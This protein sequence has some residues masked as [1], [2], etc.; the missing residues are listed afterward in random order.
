MTARLFAV[1]RASRS[2]PSLRALVP[3]NL[4]TGLEQVLCAIRTGGIA[5]V[6]EAFFRLG[7]QDREI[8]G[9]EDE[10][11]KTRFDVAAGCTELA[12]DGQRVNELTFEYATVFGVELHGGFQT[13]LVVQAREFLWRDPESHSVVFNTNVHDGWFSFN[14]VTVTCAL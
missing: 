9:V 12:L 5:C 10:Q 14:G 2:R 8:A 7:I 4:H 1:E 6:H 13:A 11:D 3:I